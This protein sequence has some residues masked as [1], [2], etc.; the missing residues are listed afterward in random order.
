MLLNS[1]HLSS[2]AKLVQL[3]QS[4]LLIFIT[5][6]MNHIAICMHTNCMIKL[7]RKLLY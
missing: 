7:L 2:T 3:V 5:K 6:F 1:N 4:D